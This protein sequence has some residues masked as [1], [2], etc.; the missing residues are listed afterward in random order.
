MTP[1]PLLFAQLVKVLKFNQ[2]SLVTSPPAP[3]N[4]MYFVGSSKNEAFFPYSSG[5]VHYLDRCY[6]EQELIPVKLIHSLV[7]HLK[8]DRTHFWED[9]NALIPEVEH[10]RV[11]APVLVKVPK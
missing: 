10:G 9:A 4:M 6:D 1:C 5:P 2:V 11:E 8:I 7:K 3:T